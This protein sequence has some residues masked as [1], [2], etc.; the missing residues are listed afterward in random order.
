MKAIKNSK[1]FKKLFINSRIAKEKTTKNWHTILSVNIYILLIIF[2]LYTIYLVVAIF[3]PNILYKPFALWRIIIRLVY[4]YVITATISVGLY[5]QRGSTGWL[6]VASILTV[7]IAFPITIIESYKFIKKVIKH[8]HLS[9]T[10]K[11][12]IIEKEFLND[13]ISVDEYKSKSK[14]ISNE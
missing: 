7:I 6:V 11:E 4:F 13:T 9:S 2:Y 14:E 12:M 3:E 5:L 1:I 8:R 10:N